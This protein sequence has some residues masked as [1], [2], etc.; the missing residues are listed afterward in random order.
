MTAAQHAVEAVGPPATI[1]GSRQARPSVGVGVGTTSNQRL[2]LSR[3]E[4]LRRGA[5]SLTLDCAVSARPAA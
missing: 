2:L 5:V 4:R 3:R 1:A